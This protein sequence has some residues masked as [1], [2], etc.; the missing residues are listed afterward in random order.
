[1][2]VHTIEY[3]QDY[4]TMSWKVAALVKF[5][6]HQ[7]DNYGIPF[8]SIGTPTGSTPIGFYQ[9]LRN[10][11][12]LDWKKIHTFNL[13]EYVGLH[14]GDKNSYRAFMDEHLFNHVPI[15]KENIHFPKLDAVYVPNA[16]EDEIASTFGLDITILGIGKNGH[17]AFNEPGS[18][19]D[20][21]TRPVELDQQTRRDNSRFFDSLEDVPTTAVTMGLSTIMK[22]KHIVLMAC[23][24]EKLDILRKAVWGNITPDVPAS[25]LQNHPKLTV[26]YCD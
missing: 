4:T 26:F 7:T 23:G 16:Y 14:P 17:I 8:F 20:S 6:Y 3:C 25:V 10:S 22:S 24:E 18:D 13:D 2:S 21:I 5:A 11:T 12:R 19:F 9:Q 15:P 1:M